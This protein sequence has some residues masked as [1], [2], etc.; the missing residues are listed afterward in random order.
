MDE[1]LKIAQMNTK[2][3]TAKLVEYESRLADQDGRIATLEAKLAETQRQF[4][5]L[6]AMA[7]NTNRG[8]GPTT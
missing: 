8:R 1:Q 7:I 3:V 4:Q 6:Q 5:I 2:A